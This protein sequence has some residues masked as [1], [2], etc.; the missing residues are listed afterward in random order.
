MSGWNDRTALLLGDDR[1]D[2]LAHSHILIVGVGGVGGWAA[3]MLARAGVG[4]MTLVDGDVVASTNINRQMVALHATVNKPKV[5][6]AK[7]R[8]LEI[9]PDL[10]ITICNEFIR[11]ERVDGLLDAAAYDFVVDA[12]DALSP[13]CY[14]IKGALDRKLKIISSMGAGAKSDPS[15]IKQ[16]D[17]W[18]TFHCGLA[19]GVRKKLQKM[20]VRRSVP[21]IFSEQQADASAIILTQEELYK[22]ST[23]GTVSY[24]PCIFGAMMAAYVIKKI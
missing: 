12:I 3:E 8:L 10:E 19:R 6:V 18:D 2:R 21:V 22:S 1:C 14:L 17:L 13:K 9:N 20:G 15:Q 11:D 5:E 16:A 23:V 24:M 4:R 7:C